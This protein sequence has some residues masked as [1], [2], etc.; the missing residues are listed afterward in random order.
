MERYFKVTNEKE[1]HNGFQ[2][3]DGLNVLIE[4]FNDD[5]E[6]SCCAGGFYFT[7]KEHIHK[8]FDFGIN[9]RIITLPKDEADFKMIR[10]PEGD[11]WRANKIIFGEKYSLLDYKTY[12][13]FG[14]DITKNDNIINY[15][16][17]YGYVNILE[18]WRKSG[19]ILLYSS[20]AIDMACANNHVNVLEWWQKS[21]L[22]LNYSSYAIDVASRNGHIDVIEW[23]HKSGLELNYSE[24]AIILASINGHIDILNWWTKSGLKIKC[25]RMPKITVDE[26]YYKN[27][28][29]WWEKSGF[30][31]RIENNCSRWA[32]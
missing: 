16:S 24:N 2:Y 31:C 21:G 32:D 9:L 11:K 12:E 23:W 26:K 19:L 29:K 27:I 20:D 4:K 6:M 10:D 14:L 1:N 13:L 30:S 28:S 17:V 25:P 18:W 5:P 15:A 8:F 7:T 22:E 3:Q